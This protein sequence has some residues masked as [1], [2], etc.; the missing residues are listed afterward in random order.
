MTIYAS[1]LSKYWEC[2]WY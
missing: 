1:G 2:Y